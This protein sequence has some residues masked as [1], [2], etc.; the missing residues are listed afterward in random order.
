MKELS[1]KVKHWLIDNDMKAG[2]LADKLGYSQA[3]LS[4]VLSGKKEN[5]ELEN[6]LLDLVIGKGVKV[7]NYLA[8]FLNSLTIN[9]MEEKFSAISYTEFIVSDRSRGGWVKDNIQKD[10][11]ERGK[12]EVIKNI[13]D[14]IC[15]G[16]WYTTVETRFFFKLPTGHYLASYLTPN[17]GDRI[18]WSIE[19]TSYTVSYSSREEA[20]EAYPEL[21]DLI[22]EE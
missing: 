13:I 17:M 7:P 2:D 10:F 20:E 16:K 5:K 1:K 19:K 21:K 8:D 14:A 12:E 6:K 4:R 3:E 9:T 18:G 22:V 11:E 15:V